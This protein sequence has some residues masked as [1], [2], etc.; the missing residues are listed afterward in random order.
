MFFDEIFYY[1]SDLI[2]F[3]NSLFI[4]K[5][6]EA[7]ENKKRLKPLFLY[8]KFFDELVLHEVSFQ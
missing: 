4:K 2:R 5:H 7:S 8:L 6:L 1:I 3:C